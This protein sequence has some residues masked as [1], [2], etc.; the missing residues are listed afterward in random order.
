MERV[1]VIGA[2]GGIGAAL[3][4]GLRHQGFD[5]VARSRSQDGFDITDEKSVVEG[6]KGLS[7]LAGVIVASGALVIDGAE[8]EKSIR[9]ISKQA[10]L[11]QFAVNSIGPALVLKHAQRILRRDGRSVFAVLTARVGSIG[12]NRL[13][14]W[15]SYRAAKAAANQIVRTG[16]IELSR[17]HPKSICVAIHPGTVKTSFTENYAGRHPTVEPKEAASNILNVLSALNAKDTGKFYDWAGS[18]VP[19]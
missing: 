7:G 15:I 11:D 3:S 14:G 2:S 12:D 4:D 5:V 10:M 6:L 16:A 17:S 19:W 13:G 9:A 8:P 18:K 1:L